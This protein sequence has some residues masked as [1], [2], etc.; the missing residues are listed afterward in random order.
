MPCICYGATSGKEDYD[1]FIESEDGK[2][3]LDHI[4]KAAS[5]IMSHK[6][7]LEVIDMNAIEFR[8][9]FVKLFLHLMV[10]CDEKINPIRF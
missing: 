4:T 1:K 9:I 7:D 10:G 3:V 8:Q 5:I 2:R 6:I